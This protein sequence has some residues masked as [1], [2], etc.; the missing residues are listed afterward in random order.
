MRA[1][2]RLSTRAPRRRGVK[3]GDAETGLGGGDKRR[4]TAAAAGD[5]VP[6]RATASIDGQRCRARIN[7]KAKA[8]QARDLAFWKLDAFARQ[9]SLLHASIDFALALAVVTAQLDLIGRDIDATPGRDNADFARL[10]VVRHF[11]RHAAHTV[12]GTGV[13]VVRVDARKVAHRARVL[14]FS[15][16]HDASTSKQK[17]EERELFQ[18]FRARHPR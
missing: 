11:R 7:K 16:I 2:K 12:A 6:R 17:Y 14:C 8:A 10:V 1:W 4:K 9:M 5:L 13:E 15:I 3:P 18:T